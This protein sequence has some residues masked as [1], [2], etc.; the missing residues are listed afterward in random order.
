[1]SVL[2]GGEVKFM[3]HTGDAAWFPGAVITHSEAGSLAL[4]PFKSADV[5][6]IVVVHYYG[7]LLNGLPF[8]NL[9]AD[10]D[11]ELNV[12]GFCLTY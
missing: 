1:M 12:F 11:V 7:S 9:R 4:D 8:L 10:H 3:E 2:L 5:C 6:L